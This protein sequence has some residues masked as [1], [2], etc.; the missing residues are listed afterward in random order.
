MTMKLKFDSLSQV[1]HLQQ[2]AQQADCPVYLASEDETLRVDA[3]TFL[4]LFSVDF[5]RPVKVITDS[6]YV[7]RRLEHAARENDIR[8]CEEKVG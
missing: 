1:E 3:R 8:V 2:L 4:G 5:S 7:I 6:L